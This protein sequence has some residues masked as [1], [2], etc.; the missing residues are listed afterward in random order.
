MRSLMVWFFM[1]W[2]L[3]ANVQAQERLISPGQGTPER[4]AVLD[5]LRPAVEKELKGEVIFV[6]DTIRA[7]RN[8]AFVMANPQRKDGKK[9]DIVQ[10]FGRDR[11]QHMDGLKVTALLQRRGSQWVLIEH[12]IGATDVWYADYCDNK[13]HKVP[14]ELLEVC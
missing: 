2:A 5:A 8:W 12:Q 13:A 9:F 11:S 6:V 4:K 14:K 7:Y 10:I 1:A 3:L